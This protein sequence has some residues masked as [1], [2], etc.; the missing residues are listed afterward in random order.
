MHNVN[1][2]VFYIV[3]TL[4]LGGGAA[5]MTGRNFASNWRQYHVAALAGL[6]LAV[7]VRFLHFALNNEQLLTAT[8]F[9]LD[10]VP[11][12]LLALLGFRWRRT[13]Q[14]TSQYYW[15]Y[16]RTGPLTWRDKPAGG[17]PGG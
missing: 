16:E 17:S 5:V 6:G 15:L 10:A 1:P 14:M 11:I 4:I 12:I 3:L 8:G 7:A 9:L 2:T 13:E